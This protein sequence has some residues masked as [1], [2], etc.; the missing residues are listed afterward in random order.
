MLVM[1]L[2][3]GAGA[4]EKIKFSG[5]ERTP[6]AA[7]A[8]PAFDAPDFLGTSRYRKDPL[9]EF[10]PVQPAP[11]VLPPHA[12]EKRDEQEREQEQE[13]K[14][15][16]EK[17][18]SANDRSEHPAREDRMGEQTLRD[19][20]Q[21]RRAHDAR[22]SDRRNDRDEYSLTSTNRFRFGR[23]DETDK[24][25]GAFGTRRESDGVSLAGG[26][27]GPA[28]R[29]SLSPG[30]GG[31]QS[32]LGLS[33][34]HD[35]GQ[36]AGAATVH[37]GNDQRV[38][39]SGFGNA[40][41]PSYLRRDPPPSAWRPAENSI[42]SGGKRGPFDTGGSFSSALG[43]TPRTLNDFNSVTSFGGAAKP[44]APAPPADLPKFEPKPAV[45]EIPKRKL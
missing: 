36:S 32:L 12:R 34:R 43:G 27:S 30:A 10:A 40:S 21:S 6:G 3:L 14:S 24:Q 11:R 45:L 8:K 44:A 35:D 31:S 41:L 25:G 42:A 2:V 18:G 9:G 13:G 29:V 5:R 4:G 39:V 33:L 15:D 26:Q 7:P 1:S 22:E 16:S 38:R 37:L 17:R 28:P 20:P 23:R 19:S